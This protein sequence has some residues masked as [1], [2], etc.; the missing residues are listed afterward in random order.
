MKIR[1]GLTGLAVSGALFLAL[2]TPMREASPTVSV[3]PASLDARGVVAREL[4]SAV[5]EAPRAPALEVVAESRVIREAHSD[6]GYW[7]W[8]ERQPALA[9]I[10][11]R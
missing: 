2:S 4:T 1:I 8:Q 11:G 10:G 7:Y 6:G 9:G 3:A 5:L